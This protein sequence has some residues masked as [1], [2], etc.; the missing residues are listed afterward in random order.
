MPAAGRCRDC[1]GAVVERVA[2]LER[3]RATEV[4][5]LAPAAEPGFLRAF[6]VAAGRVAAVRSL[7]ADRPAWLE[8]EAGLALARAAA[9]AGPAYEPEAAD[10]LLVLG[11]FLR[12]PPPELA[13]VPLEA[14]R[15]A[16]AG[17]HPRAFVA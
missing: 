2:A 14:G 13:I 4:C 16:A 8:I 9:A 6:F 11:S 17:A 3:L 12:R 7:P 10:E 1:G 15:I 5:V